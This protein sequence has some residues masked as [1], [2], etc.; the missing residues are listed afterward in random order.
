MIKNTKNILKKQSADEH[1][2]HYAMSDCCNAIIMQDKDLDIDGVREF[3][4]CTKCLR[5][6]NKSVVTTPAYTDR[7][8]VS[9]GES[10]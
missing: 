2:A 8:I 3:K 9:T 10:E 6:C 1:W 4:R 5:E 7:M